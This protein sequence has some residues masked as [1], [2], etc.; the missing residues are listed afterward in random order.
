MFAA[1]LLRHHK[2]TGVIMGPGS[3][4]SINLTAGGCGSVALG[5]NAAVHSCPIVLLL[6]DDGVCD[7]NPAEEYADQRYQ[8][9]LVA[10]HLLLWAP[11]SAAGTP[12]QELCWC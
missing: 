2:S 12:S 8:P 5:A 9:P 1:T 4:G 11:T 10:E 3:A 6:G 7:D